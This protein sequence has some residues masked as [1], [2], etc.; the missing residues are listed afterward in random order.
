MP[1]FESFANHITNNMN[2]SLD[3]VV[4]LLDNCRAGK[5]IDFF[6]MIK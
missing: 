4:I 1:F 2:I 6:N 5:S 3:G